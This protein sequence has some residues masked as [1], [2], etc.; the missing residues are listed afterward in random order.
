MRVVTRRDGTGRARRRV[1]PDAPEVMHGLDDS[2]LGLANR[3]VALDPD[4]TIEVQNKRA[5][6]MAVKRALHEEGVQYS[7]LFLAR[8]RVITED[9]TAF[10]QTPVEAWEWLEVRGSGGGNR[11]RMD[12]PRRRGRSGPRRQRSRNRL[13]VEPTM[14]QKESAKREALEAVGSMRSK[15]SSAETSE[16]DLDS[17]VAGSRCFDGT[18]KVTP[19][20]ADELG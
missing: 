6:F 2:R 20:T 10:F 4:F 8:L 15:A 3:V 7:L 11:T 12:R 16:G 1:K 9:K 17:S 18:P 14:A 19:Q 13:L 5:S